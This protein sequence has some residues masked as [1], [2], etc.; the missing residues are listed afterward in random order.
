MRPDP[1]AEALMK[2]HPEYYT[3]PVEEPE[4]E[5]TPEPPPPPKP[6][7]PPTRDVLDITTKVPKTKSQCIFEAVEKISTTSPMGRASV[8]DIKSP[9]RHKTLVYWRQITFFLLKKHTPL[10]YPQIGRMV[11]NRDHSTV[12]YAVKK[13]ES[14]YKTYEFHIQ[15]AERLI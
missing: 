5:P 13:I 15:L 2:H 4:P 10:S 7:P 14:N 9:R 11:G 6:T 3:G 8:R 1:L 12:H